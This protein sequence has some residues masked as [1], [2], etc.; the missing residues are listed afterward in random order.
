MFSSFYIKAYLKK[1]PSS[2]V[3]ANGNILTNGD[4]KDKKKD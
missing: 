1:K 4:V 2:N 3:D